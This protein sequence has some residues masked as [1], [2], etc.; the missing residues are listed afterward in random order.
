MDRTQVGF[1]RWG[2][3]V[4]RLHVTDGAVGWKLLRRIRLH[5]ERMTRPVLF[6][7]NGLSAEGWRLTIRQQD[8]RITDAIRIGGD[9]LFLTKIEQTLERPGFLTVD[10]AKVR[11][12]HCCAAVETSQPGPTFPAAL[13]EKYIRHEQHM[14]EA[15]N[16]LCYV[17][18]TPKCVDLTPGSLVD[19]DGEPYEVLLAH[20][21]D[22]AKNE[23]EIYRKADL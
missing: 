22:E 19:V 16:L 13:T 12:V 2:A 4:V 14:P 21:L 8:I 15:V 10:A 20:R 9:H 17:L 3:E 5:A 6:S 11:T 7:A 18:V 23:Y 1:W